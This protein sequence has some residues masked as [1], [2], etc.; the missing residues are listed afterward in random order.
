MMP[1]TIVTA[2]G[3]R[4]VRLLV[5]N[6]PQTVPELLRGVDVT[7]TAVVEQLQELVAAGL[8]ERSTE[9]LPGRGRPRHRYR[10]T[11]AA[12]AL[13]GSSHQRLVTPAIWQAIREIGGEKM[14]EQVLKRVSHAVADE[15]CR[16]I[17]AKEPRERL[18]QFIRLRINEG[19]V[20]E[21][22][23]NR[24]GQLVVYKRSCPFVNVSDPWRQ[25]CHIDQQVLAKVAGRPIRRLSC[26]HEG[27]PCCA[28]EIGPD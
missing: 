24:S 11:D 16:K 12:M 23:K 27:D 26:R 17:T 10:A 3:M 1:K 7:R 6:P 18:R 28:F 20:M 2:A 15:Y 8:V 13:L 4:I 21:M 19:G 25:I 5:G 22:K 9:R 14:C